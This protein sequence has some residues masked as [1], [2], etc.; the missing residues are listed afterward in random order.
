VGYRFNFIL[1]K[2]D[3]C[4]TPFYFYLFFFYSFFLFFKEQGEVGAETWAGTLEVGTLEVGTR[5][6]GTRAAGTLA[7]GTL[8]VDK[9]EADKLAGKLAVGSQDKPSVGSQ[10]KPLASGTP[11]AWTHGCGTSSGSA[12]GW[13]KSRSGK[14]KG[15]MYLDPARKNATSYFAKTIHFDGFDDF[16]NHHAFPFPFLFPFLFLFLFHFL[17][18]EILENQSDELVL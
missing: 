6:V 11:S 10:D 8:A 16:L 7:A 9:R 14:N 3:V 4:P 12:S 1:K 13:V 17:F 15:T 5:A 18:V 2:S